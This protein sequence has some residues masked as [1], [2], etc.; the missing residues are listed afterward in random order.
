MRRIR[1]DNFPD[2]YPPASRPVRPEACLS[3]LDDFLNR[4][5]SATAEAQILESVVELNRKLN[6]LFAGR[7]R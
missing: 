7:R 6:D 3:Y 5:S 1:G 4:L 2:L